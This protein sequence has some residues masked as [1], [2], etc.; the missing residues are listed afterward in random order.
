MGIVDGAESATV[1]VSAEH[2]GIDLN[3][4]RPTYYTDSEQQALHAGDLFFQY[5][6]QQFDQQIVWPDKAYFKK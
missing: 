2:V 4:A 3:R 5:T 1:N 6:S